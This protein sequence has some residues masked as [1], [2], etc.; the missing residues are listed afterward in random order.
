[1]QPVRAT[2][3]LVFVNAKHHSWLS[4]LARTTLPKLFTALSRAQSHN[5]ISVKNTLKRFFSFLDKLDGKL[6]LD[7]ESVSE[8]LLRLICHCRTTTTCRTKWKILLAKKIIKLNK[9]ILFY[10]PAL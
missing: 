8:L 10:F 9:V 5:P 1:M 3:W 2:H 6:V 7:M 4:V